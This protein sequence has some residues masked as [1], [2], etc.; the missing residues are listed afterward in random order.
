MSRLVADGGIRSRSTRVFRI[1]GSFDIECADWNQFVV[2][3]TF[4][5]EDGSRVWYDVDEMIDY[6]RR[7]GGVWVAHGGGVYDMLLVL[8]RA[9]TRMIPCQSDASQHRVT[10]IVMGKLTIRDSYSLWPAPLEHLCGAIGVESPSLPWPCNCRSG[11]CGVAPCICD[12]CCGGFCRIVPGMRDPDLEEYCRADSRCLYRAMVALCEWATDHGLSLRGTLGQ[13]A[14]I[15]A[16]EELGIPDSDIPLHL[17]KHAKQADKGGRIS[18]VRPRSTGVVGAHHDICNAYPGQLARAE[19]PVGACGELGG[20]MARQMLDDERPGIYTV[21]VR[22]PDDVFLPPLPWSKGGQLCFPTG[23][24]SG[25]WTLPEI[26]AALERG[27]EVT[28]VHTALVWEATAPIFGPLVERWYDLRRA[29]GRKTPLGQWIGGCAKALTGKLAERPDRERLVLFPSE[30][31]VC[32]RRGACRGGCTGRCRAHKPRDLWGNIWSVPYFQM[33]KS[34]YPQWSAY[35]RA[36]TRVQWLGQAERMGDGGRDLCMG[37]TDSLWHTSRETPQPLGDG[38]GQWEYQHAWTDLE[39][40]SP[41]VYAYRDPASGKL[42]VRGVPGL[43]EDDWKRGRGQI[44]RGIL[45]IGRSV[46]TTG[47]LFQRRHRKWRLPSGDRTWYGDRKIA[48]DGLTYP[49]DAAEL[50][51]LAKSARTGA[52]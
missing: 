10:R 20:S 21:S 22:V 2:G 12:T 31:K 17:W 32:L 42:E 41:T 48:A 34:A 19:L 36:L 47:G 5:A 15:S 51:H 40:R 35:L 25:T 16:Q 4:C 30:I 33:A 37:N 18:I 43:T 6:M 26:L 52:G 50:R 46:K 29:A 44:D 24:F 11:G 13:T 7:R 49:V 14:W 1:V 3:T 8:E 39:V 27:T 45:T 38:L 28:Q 9:R 23:E